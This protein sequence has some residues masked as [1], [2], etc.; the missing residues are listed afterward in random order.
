M[1]RESVTIV[2]PLPAKVLHPNTMIASIGGRLCK[3]AATKRFRRLA[4]EAVER[5]QVETAPWGQ[6]LVSATFYHSTKR[7]RDQ[8]GAMS[9]LKAAY[10]GIVDAGLVENDDPKHMRREIPEF[11]TDRGCPR[12]VLTITRLQ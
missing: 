6:A 5:E 1:D 7:C 4:M 2:L 11:D 8:D 3:A 10:D 9:S 12:V